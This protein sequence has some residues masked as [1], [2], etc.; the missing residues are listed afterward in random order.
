MVR[1]LT[2]AQC[3]ENAAFLKALRQIGNV[4]E[5]ARQVGAHR[6][7]FTKRRV[8]HPA[9]AAEW[10]MALAIAHAALH[11]LKRTGAKPRLRTRTAASATEPKILR[12]ASGRL[13]V[14]RTSAGR[15]TRAAEQ[16]FLAALSATANVRL[17]AAAAGFSHSAFY[18]RRRQN[19]AFAREMRMALEMGY[20]RIEAAVLE[21]GLA[22]S[23]RDDAWRHN[24]PPPVPPLSFDQAMQVLQLHQKEVRLQAEPPHIKRRRGESQ[25]AYSFRLGAMWEAERARDREDYAVRRAAQREGRG[26]SPHE[27]EA[28]VLPDLAQVRPRRTGKA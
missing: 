7:K 15:L 6:A 18:A 27:P 1:P 20:E 13:Q 23:Y 21:A 28:P 14:R 17:A 9:F 16:A 4:R 2:R 24:D 3:L 11:A 26:Q 22:D 5:A 25:E 19:P 8:K 12:T 10:D